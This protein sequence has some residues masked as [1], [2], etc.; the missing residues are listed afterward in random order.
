LHLGVT[1]LETT[2]AFLRGRGCQLEESEGGWRLAP[3]QA[4]GIWLYFTEL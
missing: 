4:S 3:E 1:R 2:L